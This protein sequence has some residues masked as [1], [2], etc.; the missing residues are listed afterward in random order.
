MTEDRL[1]IRRMRQGDEGAL[2]CIYERYKDD[3]VTVAAC[4]LADASAAEDVLHDVFVDFAAGID[5][6][7]LRRNLRG[8]LVTCVANRAR[9]R[10]RAASR[11]AVPLAE[12]H[13]TTGDA[14]SPA[15]QVA[16]CEET[17]I[18]YRALAELP[19]EQREAIT[20]HVHGGMRFRQ[21]AQ[22]L[23]VSINTVQSRYRYGLEKLR[24]LLKAGVSS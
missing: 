8:Y 14:P 4:L 2:R 12:T 18:L 17:Q 13:D 1:L 21:I 10:L 22:D 15:A 19:T 9:D 3:L 24:S 7:Q 6:F 20:L 23:G 5:G 11:R 16:E